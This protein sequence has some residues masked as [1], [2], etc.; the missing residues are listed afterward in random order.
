MPWGK[1]AFFTTDLIRLAE[2][3]KPADI[4]EAVHLGAQH[5]VLMPRALHEVAIALPQEDHNSG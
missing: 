5:F 3:N 4:A 2:R 1:Q